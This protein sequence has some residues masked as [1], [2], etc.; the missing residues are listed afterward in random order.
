MSRHLQ[1]IINKA[2]KKDKSLEEK[3]SAFILSVVSFNNR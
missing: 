2:P 3:N 1:A